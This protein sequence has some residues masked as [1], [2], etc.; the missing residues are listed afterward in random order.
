[1]Q[2][3]EDTVRLRHMLESAN[4]ACTF[5]GNSSF[6][7]FRENRMM[8]NAI[9][10]SLEVI[11]EAASQVSLDFKNNH[12][13][14]EW[15]IIVGMRNRLVHAYFDINFSVVWETVRENL[16]PFIEQLKN[17]LKEK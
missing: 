8:A 10:R 11:R 3:L 5:L 15:R 9:I 12:P 7:E 16:P 2:Q 14:I 1:M 6:E 4:E 13:E 17:I